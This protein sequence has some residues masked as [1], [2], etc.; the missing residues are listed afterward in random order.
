MD[1]V[2]RQIVPIVHICIKDVYSHANCLDYYNSCFMDTFNARVKAFEI[3]NG[4][5]VTKDEMNVI[6]ADVDKEL[7]AFAKRLGV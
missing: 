7:K 3:K 1:S 5:K 6:M 2:I 4:R